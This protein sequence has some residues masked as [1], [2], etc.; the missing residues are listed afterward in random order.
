MIPY[1]LT[2]LPLIWEVYNDRNGDAHISRGLLELPSKKVDILVRVLIATIVA[3]IN[4]F[5]FDEALFKSVFLCVAV[6]FLLFD[7]IIAF[8]LI[9]KGIIK[10]HW[11][12]YM[13]SK[14]ID[15]YKSWKNVPPI[16]K[17]VIRIT[18]FGIANYI[19]FS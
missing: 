13:G 9:K 2:L 12:S 14:G 19:Y 17:L 16:I 6:H 8:I 4:F 7:Y 10:G 3:L 5:V 18:I 15:N 1:I 11:F